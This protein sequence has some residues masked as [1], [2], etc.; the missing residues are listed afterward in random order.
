MQSLQQPRIICENA[1]YLVVYKPPFMHSA[2]L[3]VDETQNLFL[4]CANRYPEIRMVRGKKRIE[5]G[6]L[7]RLDRDTSGL[8]LFARTQASYDVLSLQQ[9]EGS[10]IK[11]YRAICSV[12]K[13]GLPGFPEHILLGIQN[14]QDTGL[15][16]AP[17]RIE[18][19]FRAYGPGQKS[20]RPLVNR[21][22][23]KKRGAAMD[24]NNP[25]CTEVV[26]YKRL[27]DNKMEFTI[28]LKRG[29]RHQIR[30]HLAWI[31][32][33]ILGDLLYGGKE[34]ETMQLYAEKISFIDP[35]IA[36][37]VEYRYISV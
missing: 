24:R 36:V 19:A 20:V 23:E 9:E 6:L 25:Y 30:S 18:S 21:E 7:H 12:N 11:E 31:G 3:R 5:G 27:P 14:E 34:S 29:F 8:V 17:F 2:P 1:G 13:N 26:S 32:Y 16:I 22:K 35:D 4:W 10:F 37:R 33:P 15:P 28:L